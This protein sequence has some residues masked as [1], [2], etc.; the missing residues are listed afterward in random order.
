MEYEEEM[1]RRMTRDPTT[2]TTATYSSPSYSSTIDSMTE[3]ELGNKGQEEDLRNMA[4]SV[5]TVRGEGEGVGQE[6]MRRR[7][8]R[9]PTT[10]TTAAYSSCSS[11]SPTIDSLTEVELETLDKGQE[12]DLGKMAASSVSTVRGE[13]EGVGED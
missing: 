7:M 12:D 11:Y 8:T 3:A 13:G 5:S 6:E 2:T 1:R 10:T 4:A 9:G